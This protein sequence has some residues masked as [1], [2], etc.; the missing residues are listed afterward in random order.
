VLWLTKRL[1]GAA[2][3]CTRR[4]AWVPW[5]RTWRTSRRSCWPPPGAYIYYCVPIRV[6]ACTPGTLSF[7][8]RKR[9]ALRTELRIFI[10][11]HSIQSL[12]SARASTLCIHVPA[13]HRTYYAAK[14]ENWIVE[15][16]APTYMIRVEKALEEERQ[17]VAAYLNAETE[18]KLLQVRLLI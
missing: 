11:F 1:F 15:D 7:T 10:F 4:W 16:S 12:F 18:P 5:T 17:R 3:R 9:I 8:T 6:V 14:V 13:P 2:L